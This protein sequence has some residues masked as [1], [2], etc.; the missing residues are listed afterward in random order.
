MRTIRVSKHR[1]LLLRFR[2]STWWSLL[3]ELRERGRGRRESGAFLF[4]TEASRPLVTEFVLYDDLDPECLTGGIDFHSIGYH[5]L[6]KLC[7]E[8]QVRVIA[9]VHTHPG[10]NPGQSQIDRDH[11]MVS[12]MGHVA[13]IIPN[14]AQGR[15]RPADV[16][17]HRLQNDG[18]WDARYG[19][20]AAGCIRIGWRL[21]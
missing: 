7:R 12:R 8:R 21:W 2:R 10:P 20:Q 18:K 6:S 13:L 4:T 3:R 19:R 16:G 11:P 9:D 14:F 5:R 1:N 15:I 17:V